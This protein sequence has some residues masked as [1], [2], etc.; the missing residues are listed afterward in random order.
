MATWTGLEKAVYAS[1][2]VM[3]DPQQLQHQYDALPADPKTLCAIVQGLLI[4]VLHGAKYGIS[5]SQDCM[6]ELCLESI[7]AMLERIQERDSRPLTETR[8]P[9][10][11]LPAT[12]RDY[13]LFLCSMLRHH[14]IPARLRVGFETYFRQGRFGDHWIC[15]YWNQED[16]R[17]VRV[18]AQLDAVHLR[19]FDIQFD[20]FDLPEGAYYTAGSMWQRC[21]EGEIDPL[22]C[23]ALNEW[24]MSYV[25]ANVIRDLLCVNKIE[26]FPW[27]GAVLANK[28]EATLTSEDQALVARTAA[29]IAPDVLVPEVFELYRHHP[30][31]H[32]HRLTLMGMT[33]DPPVSCA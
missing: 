26:N 12:C 11:R 21:S 16:K 15:E 9:E 13:A 19:S 22:S 14:D 30:V 31:L 32:A 20:P 5:L 4:H 10:N 3:S 28:P 27:D 23:G 24:G 25:R 6:S 2:S 18:D 1:H 7:P 29:C 8:T 17:W 33:A